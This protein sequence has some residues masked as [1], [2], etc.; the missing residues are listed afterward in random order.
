MALRSSYA[1]TERGFTL[2]DLLIVLILIG[3]LTA[4]AAPA[5]IKFVR[6]ANDASAAANIRALLPA[7]SAYKADNDDT[8]GFASMTIGGPAGLKS[9]DKELN[10]WDA[11]RGTG[12]T[13]LSKSADDYCIKSVSGGA[14]YYQDGPGKPIAATPACS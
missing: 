3:I 10:G 8:G 11:A 13:V 14:T 9:Y 4:I 7:V 1:R 12:V 6:R 5:Y 2:V